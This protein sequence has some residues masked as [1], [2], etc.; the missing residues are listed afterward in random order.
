M[1]DTSDDLGEKQGHAPTSKKQ[2]ASNPKVPCLSLKPE[3]LQLETRN[4]ESDKCQCLWFLLI[5]EITV[6]LDVLSRLDLLAFFEKECNV[7][8]QTPCRHL[9]S[10]PLPPSM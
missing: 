6:D 8:S 3:T 10:T 2:E 4:F 9:P 1:P 7:N 5:D